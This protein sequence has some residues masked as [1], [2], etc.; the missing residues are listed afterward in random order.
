MKAQRSDV[1]GFEPRLF[2]SLP[3]W[4]HS[5][6]AKMQQVSLDVNLHVLAIRGSAAFLRISPANLDASEG[7]F[8]EWE[9]T[10]GPWSTSSGRVIMDRNEL[11]AAFG[12]SEETGKDGNWL[13]ERY[14]G[15]SAVQGKF[16]RSGNYLNI[17]CPGT[18]HDGD[19][20]ISIELS[21]NIRDAV[22]QL[23]STAHS[24]RPA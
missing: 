4:C 22:R 6:C 11:E 14:G 17:P 19:P 7:W 15:D 21:D 13:L 24:E 1:S 10:H 3:D 18:G 23:L 12:L 2:L 20:N 9:I 8:V 16:M 5:H